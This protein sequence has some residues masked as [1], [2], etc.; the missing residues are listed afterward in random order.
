MP[1]TSPSFAGLRVASFESRRADEMAK[2]I[3][4]FGGVPCVSPSMREVKLDRNPAAIAFAQDII[5]GRFDI[6]VLMTGVGLRRLLD[7]ISAEVN[8]DEF[9]TAL[10]QTITVCRGPK[11]VVVMRE[12]G[13]QPTHRVP[14]PNTWRELLA[15]LDAHCPVAGL[16][17]GLQEYGVPND[18]LL[19]AL[20]TRG[21]IVTA[22]KVY[23]WDF[24]EDISPL[25]RNARA[26]AAGE[27]DVLLF[28]SSR[29]VVNLLEV[30][31]RLGL[32]SQVRQQWPRMVVGS[33]GPTMSE[34]LREL[35]LSYDFEPE[36]PKMGHL[37]TAAAE[38][39]AEIVRGKR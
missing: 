14:E 11:P 13:L 29:Q 19:E 26:L 18:A 39:A 24:P 23:D 15:T 9:I 27:L 31:N 33:I 28:T 10:G 17:V 21:A 34:T 20:K 22:V 12:L 7:D 3:E 35:E 30:A 36:H 16:R 1:D 6:V 2:M 32:A 25:E 4:K 38:C 5:A 37:V 8:R